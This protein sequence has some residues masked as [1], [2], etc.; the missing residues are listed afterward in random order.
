MLPEAGDAKRFE[1][2]DS[3]QRKHVGH[4]DDEGWF[5]TMQE[6]ERFRAEKVDNERQQLRVS[7]SRFLHATMAVQANVDL[8]T[9][10]PA[11]APEHVTKR[12]V[13][14]EVVSGGDMGRRRFRKKAMT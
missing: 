13:C 6:H 4:R 10:T 11:V 8:P 12:G 5:A 2:F 1:G 3:G 14:R 7:L 9:P